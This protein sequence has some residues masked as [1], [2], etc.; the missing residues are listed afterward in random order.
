LLSELLHVVDVQ[1]KLV[2]VICCTLQQS[3]QPCAF[4]TAV[5][6][7]LIFSASSAYIA[8]AAAA[9][10]R[11]RALL[12]AACQAVVYT[13]QHEHFGIVPLEAMASGRP[14]IA[15]NN[16]GPTESV[17][18]GRTGQLCE[19]TA[20]AFADAY[21]QLLDAKV[22]AKMGAAARKH[23]VGT[24]SRAAFGDRLNE[25]VQTLAA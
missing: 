11:Q 18:S 10:C 13:P 20:A 7:A 2:A 6:A 19:P 17:L 21:A 4:D 9:Y 24:F 23:V 25:H 3:L 16:G 12:L 8:S 1:S 14:V 15:V 22:A 5:L